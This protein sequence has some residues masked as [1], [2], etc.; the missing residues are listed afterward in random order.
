MHDTV[1]SPLLRSLK[2]LYDNL[3]L[4]ELQGENRSQVHRLEQCMV[5]HHV[6]VCRGGSPDGL[7]RLRIAGLLLKLQLRL[8]HDA[9]RLVGQ[10]A[11]RVNRL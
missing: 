8:A 2:N 5:A 6:A 7:E 3:I 4:W 1:H 9:H 11:E 10:V